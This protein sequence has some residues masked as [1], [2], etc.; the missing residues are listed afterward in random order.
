MPGLLP[1]GCDC[2]I[3]C[4]FKI[5]FHNWPIIVVGVDVASGK[6]EIRGQMAEGA[7]GERGRAQEARAVV[8]S[9][10][11]CFPKHA[12]AKK[13]E[14][15]TRVL[16]LRWYQHAHASVGMAPVTGPLAF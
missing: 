12:Q 5:S 15:A 4:S 16:P 6:L 1:C 8:V 10:E 13:L 9:Y 7:R 2:F 3:E 11:S 14:H